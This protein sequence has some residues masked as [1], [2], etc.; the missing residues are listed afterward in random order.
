MKKIFTLGALGLLASFGAQAQITVDGRIMASEVGAGAGQYRSIGMYTAD[1][2]TGTGHGY[3]PW[4]LKEAYMAEDANYIYIGVNGTVEPNTDGNSLFVFFNASNQPM[5]PACDTIPRAPSPTLDPTGFSAFN[6]ALELPVSAA[7]AFRAPGGVG[8]LELADYR[9]PVAIS[10]VL[11]PLTTD[12]TAAD[13]ATGNAIRS[14]YLAPSGNIT[15]N[16]NEGWE[17]RVVKAAYSL[18][19]GM[20]IQLFVLMGNQNGGYLSSDFIPMSTDVTALGVNLDQNADFCLD[21]A[22][23]QYVTYRLGTGLVSGLKK[24]D[25]AS[26]NFSVAPNPVAGADASVS[27]SLDKAQTGTVTVSDM[28]GRQVATLANGT[29]PAG[30]QR[31]TLKAANLTAGQYIVKLQL[32]DKVATRKV[33]VL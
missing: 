6:H 10:T 12:G 16:T 11:G 29:L 18:T 23:T 7:L 27:F 26:L 32:G 25:A 8:Q 14:A 4:G 24:V 31:F 22:G 30:N 28:L 21:V 17:I 5:L 3:G 13:F 15:T 9:G 19:T 1:H 20:D 2:V 33:A